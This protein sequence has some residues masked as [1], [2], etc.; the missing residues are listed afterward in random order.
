MT[1]SIINL[2]E[3]KEHDR[4]AAGSPVG[5]ACRIRKSSKYYGQTKPGELFPVNV[6]N[7]A[8]GYIFVGLP[9][10][11]RVEDVDLFA[12]LSDGSEVQISRPEASA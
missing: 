10:D 2:S 4:K 11:Y 3:Y 12:I 8:G 1:M 9:G 7:N 5:L 6:V